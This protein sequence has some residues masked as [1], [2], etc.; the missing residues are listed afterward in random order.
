MRPPHWK[1]EPE[2]PPPHLRTIS[3]LWT[4]AAVLGGLGAAALAVDVPLARW[5]ASDAC[6]RFIEK[7]CG[8]SETFAHG[9]GI[10][11]IAAVISVLDP[12]HRKAI[13]RIAT[14]ALGSGLLAN[15]FKLFVA[16]DRPRHFD[17]E[18]DALAS[19]SGWFPMLGNTS[20]QQ[21]FPSAHAATAA[22]LAVALACLYP[23]GRWL[24]PAL[25]ALAAF[26][27]VLV[28]AHFLSD[29]L[30]GAAVGCTFAPLCI[31][32]SRLSQAFDR[33]E[34]WFASRAAAPADRRPSGR[35]RAVAPRHASSD[36]VHRAA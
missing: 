36:E 35:P 19:F 10:A 25:A 17:F 34:S 29:V 30:W 7:L 5:A 6:P 9:A 11:L 26:Q 4:F 27:R 15:V 14:A 22:G 2:I 20:G 1:I 23:R 31:Y 3:R 16:R 28:Q 21:G 24:F 13:P 18:G 32:G 8:L 12:C 33:L